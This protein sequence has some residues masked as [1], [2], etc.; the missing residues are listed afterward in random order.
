MCS[1]WMLDLDALKLDY[2]KFEI[3]K[4]LLY[5]DKSNV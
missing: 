4:G 5:Y 3:K 2:V 1:R